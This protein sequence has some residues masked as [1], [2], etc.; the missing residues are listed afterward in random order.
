MRCVYPE[1]NTRT[2]A[3]SLP[4]LQ[5]EARP[6]RLPYPCLTL[7]AYPHPLSFY[8]YEKACPVIPQKG[9]S[10][11]NMIIFLQLGDT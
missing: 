11:E 10:E 2:I 4:P 8:R 5:T 6:A 7:C 1:G 9:L 3:A